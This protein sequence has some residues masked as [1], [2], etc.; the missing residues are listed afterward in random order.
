MQSTRG[1]PTRSAPPA[2]G[3]IGMNENQPLD[4]PFRNIGGTYGRVRTFPVETAKSVWVRA[5]LALIYYCS[6]YS[7]QLVQI[8]AYRT[9]CTVVRTCAI[10]LCIFPEKQYNMLVELIATGAQGRGRRQKSG[11]D[12]ML[13]YYPMGTML[14]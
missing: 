3:K 6:R 8:W 1:Q 10:F 2:V 4:H 5:Y 12:G 13:I 14:T 9:F 11:I 7:S